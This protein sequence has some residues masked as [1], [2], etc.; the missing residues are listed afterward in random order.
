MLLALL[1]YAPKFYLGAFFMT[2]AKK[3]CIAVLAALAGLALISIAVYCPLAIDRGVAKTNII[4]VV[5][6]IVIGV[7]LCAVAAVGVV[8][9]KRTDNYFTTQRITK[10]AVFSA[11]SY[12]LYMFVKFPLPFLF[13]SFLDV[14]ISDVPALLAGF[15]MGP[16]SGA[17][18]VAIKILLKLPFS[19]TGMVGELG[20]FI[21]G[22]AFVIPAAI[23][24][25]YKRTKKGA[26]LSLAVGEVCCIITALIINRFVLIPFYALIFDGGMHAIVGMMKS[27]YENITVNNIYNYYLWLAVLPF[28]IL[29][30]TLCAA[31]TFLLYKSLGRLFNKLIPQKKKEQEEAECAEASAN[32]GTVNL[33]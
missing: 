30:C 22:I 5:M 23:I 9:Y 26:L 12:L 1:F 32:E 24:Y 14:Q 13:P 7:I 3:I 27:L 25:H 11:L 33:N 28:N 6:I 16:V 4:K 31:I 8:L 17:I 10:L 15:M 2:K 20:D 21:M 19:S 29:R 18:V